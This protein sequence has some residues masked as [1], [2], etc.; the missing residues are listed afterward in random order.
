MRMEVKIVD[1]WSF[2][3]IIGGSTTLCVMCK[4][5]I[6]GRIFPFLRGYLNFIIKRLLWWRTVK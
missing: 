6:F 2:K 5:V 1:K 4:E 3:G